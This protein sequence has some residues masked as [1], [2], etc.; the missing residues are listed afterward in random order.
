MVEKKRDLNLQAGLRVGIL[1][2]YLT[3]MECQRTYLQ[4]TRHGRKVSS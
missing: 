2:G 1:G 4:Q 3:E